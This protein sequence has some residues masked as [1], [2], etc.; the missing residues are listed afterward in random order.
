M[1]KIKNLTVE[2]NDKIILK[3]ITHEFEKGKIYVIM[4]PNGSGKSTLAN[5]VAGHPAYTIKKGDIR[6][7]KKSI[8]SLP[9]ETR[10]KQGIFMTFQSP[11][12]LSGVTI[13]QLM[14]YALNG[15]KNP[16]TIR[17]MVQEYAKKLHISDE[18]LSRSLNDGFSG[19]ER[20]K[21]E[22]LQ[23]AML[24]PKIVFFDEIDTG[25]DIDALKTI[26]RFIKKLHT[27]DKVFIIITHYN[28]IINYIKP[29]NVLIIMDG[30]IVKTGNKNLITKIEKSGYSNL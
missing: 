19:G 18:L 23:V 14:R 1:L 10:A 22:V 21:M 4:G 9:A 11:T 28:R 5:V 7:N 8:L 13:Y 26:A 24:Q 6:F 27:Q 30:K 25:V 29:D 20:K 3:D 17:K 15:S 12:T 16:L 2:A